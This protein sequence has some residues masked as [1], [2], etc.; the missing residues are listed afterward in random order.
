LYR[1]QKNMA[2]TLRNAVRIHMVGIAGQ[3]MAALAQLLSADGKRVSGSDVADVFNT[4][5][6]LREL[7]IHVRPFER[8]NITQETELVI[9]TSAFGEDNPEI[10]EAKRQGI[11]V[12]LYKEAAAELFNKKR[13][14]LITGTHGKTTTTAMI[15]RILEDAG[16]DP[17]VLVG[18]PVIKWGRN[19][20]AG[21][22]AWMV[23]EGDEYEEKFLAMRPEVLVI[24]SIEYD[25]PDFF[26]TEQQYR[27]AF[28]K[29]IA[30]LPVDG[31]LIAEKG[32]QKIIKKAPCRIVWYG[33]SGASLGRHVE[34]NAQAA[35]AVA[36]HLSVPMAVAKKT[37]KNF[38]GASRRMELYTRP[39]ADCV[40]IDDYAHH[41]TEII[42]TLAA[43]RRKYPKRFITALFQP[44]TYTRT[45]AL[46]RDF[47]SSFAAAN[48]VVLLPIYSSA[49]ERADRYP[50]DLLE[51]LQAGIANHG[52][53]V[54]IMHTIE[55]AVSYGTSLM[56][57]PQKRVFI[58]LG[59][60]N[61]WKVA[62]G[63]SEHAQ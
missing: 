56:R 20:R 16:R 4:S 31:V 42:T 8:S 19:A 46:L 35:L 13:G 54:S 18:A 25:H 32:L 62:R 28:L 15:G 26:K 17:V 9:Y 41:P 11:P 22:G 37:L 6:A 61:G 38:E 24:T 21:H 53:P 43:V 14:I 44:H 52:I 5:R 36:K 47:S 49:R 27:A 12:L 63:V 29:L 48:E 23:A 50:F 60:G 40:V 2:H 3:G 51:Q 33:L 1:N 55:D 7:G 58:A 45:R 34:L 57:I 39:N 30:M 10:D 59:A